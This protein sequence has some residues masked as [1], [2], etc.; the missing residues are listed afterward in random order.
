MMNIRLSWVLAIFCLVPMVALAQPPEATTVIDNLVDAKLIPQ[1][2]Y[3]FLAAAY[4]ADSDVLYYAAMDG[5][6]F[7]PEM[8]S[9]FR[10]PIA[11]INH[12]NVVSNSDVTIKDGEK[13]E[14]GTGDDNAS[15]GDFIRL[16]RGCTI[17]LVAKN[18]DFGSAKL[19][20]G[21][22][23]DGQFAVEYEELLVDPAKEV[24]I[25][26]FECGHARKLQMEFQKLHKQVMKGN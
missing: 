1:V 9:V 7:D 15:T 10:V 22:I 23:S 13:M 24:D 14:M 20:E 25:G 17:K 12:V 8:E 4:D 16:K 26:F 5:E 21:W 3:S 6:H 2:D 11:A 18:P 19:S